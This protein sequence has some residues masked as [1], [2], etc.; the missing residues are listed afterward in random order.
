MK[1]LLITFNLH[2]ASHLLAQNNKYTKYIA[3][4]RL[5]RASAVPVMALIMI[6]T[7]LSWGSASAR[8]TMIGLLL[9]APQYTMLATVSYGFII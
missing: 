6:S 3:G 2:Q 1:A 5:S 8:L 9:A 4:S 7:Q